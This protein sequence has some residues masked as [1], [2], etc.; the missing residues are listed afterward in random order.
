MEPESLSL[1]RFVFA[2]SD[3]DVT[4]KDFKALPV[5]PCH[6]PKKRHYPLSPSPVGQHMALA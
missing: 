5:H 6:H 1:H 3:A 4:L 2:Q